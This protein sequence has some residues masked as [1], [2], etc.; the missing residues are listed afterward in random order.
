MSETSTKSVL[1][2]I[3]KFAEKADE[4]V[5]DA[6]GI[7]I[8]KGV[9][10]GDVYLARIPDDSPV[11]D[12]W[13]SRTGP[14]GQV[15]E[16]VSH[17]SRHVMEGDFTL[18]LRTSATP[19]PTP[20]E[21]KDPLYGPVICTGPGGAKLVHGNQGKDDHATVELAPNQ[22]WQTWQQMDPRTMARVQ[23]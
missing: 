22:C 4:N 19:T 1:D 21:G 15:V 20:C 18:R 11:G 6:T 8:G 7:P 12:A 3:E 10:Q 13:S 23:D 5:R 2:Q 17:G 14:I 9:R 16:G